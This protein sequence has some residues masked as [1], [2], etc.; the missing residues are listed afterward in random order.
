MCD[1][2]VYY[3]WCAIHFEYRIQFDERFISAFR[4]STL[5][6]FMLFTHTHKKS[7]RHKL[8]HIID[9]Y[10]YYIHFFDLLKLEM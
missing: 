7:P 2:W 10:F 3:A 9:L 8:N 4:Q 5:S 1:V 6:G